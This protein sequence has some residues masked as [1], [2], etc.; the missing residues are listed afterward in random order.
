MADGETATVGD[1]LKAGR[2][3]HRVRDRPRAGVGSEVGPVVPKAPRDF[4]L[5]GLIN[6]AAILQRSL[7]TALSRAEGA[8]STV[9]FGQKGI[10]PPTR[11]SIW[12]RRRRAPAT[13]SVSAM[14][15]PNPCLALSGKARPSP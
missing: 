4:C 10:L 12:Q 11:A 5:L 3:A 15:A 13:A 9:A 7:V 8:P 6:E 2:G 1:L 14:G